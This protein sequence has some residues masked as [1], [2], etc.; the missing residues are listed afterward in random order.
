MYMWGISRLPQAL[1]ARLIAAF[2]TGFLPGV[3]LCAVYCCAA[4]Y[5]CDTTFLDLLGLV[6]KHCSFGT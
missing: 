6:L 4:W 3:C 5:T 1:A 2:A